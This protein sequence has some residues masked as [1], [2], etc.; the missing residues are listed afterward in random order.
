MQKSPFAL[1]LTIL[2]ISLLL[3]ARMTISAA[4]AEIA[5]AFPGVSQVAL[6]NMVAIPSLVAIPFGVLSGIL[7]RHLPKKGLV[8]AGLVLFIV[9]GVGPLFLSSFTL[10]MVSRAL[11]G[12][13]TGLF[14][15]MAAGLFD[16]FF[17][18]PER[19]GL[20][21]FQSVS[22]GLGNIIT[23]LLAGFLATLS[24][25]YAFLMYALGVL[26]LVAVWWRLPEPPRSAPEP[27]QKAAVNGRLVFLLGASFLY[28]IIYFA[29]FGYLAFIIEGRH[30]GNAATSGI[31][32]MCMTLGSM[33]TGALFGQ[34]LRAFRSYLLTL[35]LA[36]NAVAFLL[37][38]GASTLPMFL[39]GSLTLGLGFSL[40]MPYVCM[41]CMDAVGK[42]NSTL[43]TGL[44]QTALSLGTAASPFVLQMVAKACHNLN[45]Q[46]MFRVC[47]LALLAAT[48]MAVGVALRGG[49]ASGEPVPLPAE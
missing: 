34:A 33:I 21:G 49:R 36:L 39:A 32:I 41:R 30:L 20:V 13:G 24:W 44:F 18:G 8:L 4:L 16:D 42:A 47:A 37:L 38:A 6:M 28:A 31:A 7:S 23:S 27:G 3:M 43:A 1:K 10:I 17:S 15:P 12:A 46:F 9:G 45:G 14:L 25:R 5:K 2:S 48:V 22:V 29:F 19:N 35:A 26:V 11:L 40:T